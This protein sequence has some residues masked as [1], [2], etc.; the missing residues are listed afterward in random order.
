VID[1]DATECTQRH[2]VETGFPRLLHDRGAAATL[3]AP[4]PRGAV[5]QRPGQYDAN[6]PR[7]IAEG[8]GSEQCIDRRP[9]AVL[10]RAPADGNRAAIDEEM[11]VRRSDVDAPGLDLL[12]ITRVDG[13]QRAGATEDGGQRARL[14]GR[15]VQH[16][17]HRTIEV[18]RQS[19]DNVPQTLHT[20]GGSPE[21]DDKRRGG[22][23]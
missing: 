12:A 4:Q 16:H 5:V 11:M 13:G 1:L 10:L 20:A 18:R 3:D 19:G 6:H 23:C 8:G 22:Q 15:N 2:R 14:R 17:E 7:P 21:H 9:E